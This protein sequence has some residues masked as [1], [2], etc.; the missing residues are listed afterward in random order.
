MKLAAPLFLL[1]CFLTLNVGAQL[2]PLDLPRYSD[3][4]SRLLQGKA[5]DSVKSRASFLLAETWAGIDTAKHGTYLR[6]GLQLAGKNGYLLT[7][8]KYYTGIGQMMTGRLDEAETSFQQ[9][10]NGMQ[11]F[12]TK[13]AQA[14]RARALYS[15]GVVQQLKDNQKEFTE[16]LTNQVIPLAQQS[17]DSVFLGKCYFA[18]GMVFKNTQQYA[19]AEQYGLRAVELFE[20]HKAAPEQLLAG[21]HALAEAYLLQ[22]KSSAA[23]T[24]LDKALPILRPYPHSEY[25]LDYYAADAMY[26]TS[27]NQYAQSLSS[28]DKGILL[29]QQ[30]HE[31]RK[32]LRLQGQKLNVYFNQ[33]NFPKAR[34]VMN[35]ML[36]QPA[37]AAYTTN[38]MIT[39]MTMAEAY[40]GE[41]NMK[42]AFEWQ[43][44]YSSTSDSFYQ[45]RLQNDIAAMEVKY[46][47]REKQQK[48]AVLEAQQQQNILKAKS[49]RLLN[50]LLSAGTIFLLITT[51]L[52]IIYY[53]NKRKL[54]RQQE[55]NYQQQLRELQQEQQLRFAQAM[56]EGEERER[57][58]VARDLHDGLGG[59]LAGIKINLSQQG[60][61]KD[62]NLDGVIQRLDQ[63]LSEL[64]RIARNMMPESLLKLGLSMALKDLCESLITS[65][66]AIDFQV[67]GVDPG[68]D[69]AIQANIYRIVQEVL[70]NA[71][72]HA[73]AGHIMVQCSQNGHVFLITVEDD[74][75]GFDPAQLDKAEGIGMINIRNRVDYL[76]G[77]L[78]IS[79][80]PGQGTVVNIELFL[81]Q[82]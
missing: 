11:K 62:G 66:T 59:M 53:R 64:R 12:G 77:K 47:S 23:R 70:S 33:K 79:S 8:G 2:K 48:I 82:A 28:I 44:R 58:R 81:P 14:F 1:L 54:A 19:K 20:R 22:Q 35:Y 71:V 51:V 36:S 60:P 21:Y 57:L 39:F 72:R 13:E 55:I 24:V 3:S 27:L 42:M 75:R 31:V 10:A 65:E 50:V 37:W 49:A 34:E 45:G 4:L 63:S 43:K 6:Q 80:S 32:E 41:G 56:L 29:A 7:V 68:M 9:A 25:F 40:A 17:G 52:L 69:P 26:Y 18:L 16:L 61:S 67:Y 73:G 46:Q 5:S 76:N 74:G 15:Y 38:R 78:D 30:L